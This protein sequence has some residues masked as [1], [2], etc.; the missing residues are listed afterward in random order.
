MIWIALFDSM[1]MNAGTSHLL[2]KITANQRTV[3]TKDQNTFIGSTYLFNF[4]NARALPVVMFARG[5]GHSNNSMAV[6][7][8]GQEGRIE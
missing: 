1:F 6:K 7:V 4:I 5:E 8:F 2:L 3:T